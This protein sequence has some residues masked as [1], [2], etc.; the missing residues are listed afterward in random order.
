M[1]SEIAQLRERLLLEGQ[2]IYLGLHGYGGVTKHEII[3]QRN[4]HMNQT[5]QQLDSHIGAEA[6]DIILS[7]AM[8]LAAQAYQE[9][10]QPKAHT[11]LQQPYQSLANLAPLRPRRRSRLKNSKKIKEAAMTTLEQYLSDHKIDPVR[12]SLEAGVRYLTVW[13]AT[14]EKPIFYHNALKIRVA[15]RRLTGL[16]Y[17]GPIPTLDEPPIDQLPTILGRRFKD[18]KN[19]KGGFSS[20]ESL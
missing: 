15:L 4:Q 8:E 12:L 14:K 16:A 11:N 17:T 2:A 7:E 1:G 9:E 3:R 6:T 19:E 10:Q 5:I 18:N 13:N 20:H